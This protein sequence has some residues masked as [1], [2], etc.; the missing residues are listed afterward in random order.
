MSTN[1]QVYVLL[2]YEI[3][4]TYS[5]YYDP[6][7]N[8]YGQILATKNKYSISTFFSI[9]VHSGNPIDWLLV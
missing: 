3:R 5:L 4:L 7:I 8:T 2:K 1:V 9:A 6:Q